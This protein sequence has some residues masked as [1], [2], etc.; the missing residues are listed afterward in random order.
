M[1]RYTNSDENWLFFADIAPL[2]ELLTEQITRRM[3]SCGGLYSTYLTSLAHEPILP[4]KNSLVFLPLLTSLFDNQKS[5]QTE[6][7]FESKEN[8]AF[9]PSNPRHQR[10]DQHDGPDLS[11]V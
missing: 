5:L 1:N 4:A 3:G 10:T 9:D 7:V 6:Q 2:R 8:S 11:S